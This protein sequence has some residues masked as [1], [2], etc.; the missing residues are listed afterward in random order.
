MSCDI[1]DIKISS[2]DVKFENGQLS[3]TGSFSISSR[4]K[5]RLRY[6][7][8]ADSYGSSNLIWTW[9]GTNKNILKTNF[10]D[11]VL[12]PIAGAPRMDIEFPK[13]DFYENGKTLIN[14]NEREKQQGCILK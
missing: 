8:N 3:A 1:G 2:D 12:T 10:G 7:S 13:P 9:D 5:T 14:H 6:S 4:E 11:I